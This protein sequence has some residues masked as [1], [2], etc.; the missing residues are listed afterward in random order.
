MRVN[1]AGLRFVADAIESNQD[2]YEQSE[3]GLGSREPSAAGAGISCETPACVAGFTVQFLGNFEEYATRKLSNS[4]SPDILVD[5]AQELLG[6]PPSWADAIFR[7]GTWPNHWVYPPK[8]DARLYAFC[9]GTI[10]P[11]AMEAAEFLRRLADQFEQEQGANEN[12][13]KP[14]EV[15]VYE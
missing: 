7:Y 8:K 14:V 11:T 12:V 1:V 10:I 6:L 15:T 3:W 4:F 2:D 13:R 5:Y 9:I